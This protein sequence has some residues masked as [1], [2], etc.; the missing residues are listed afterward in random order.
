MAIQTPTVPLD[1]GAAGTPSRP[2]REFWHYFR[3]S[4]GAVLG[5]AITVLL[6]LTAIFADV[7]APHDPI[8]QYRDAFLKPPVYYYAHSI[9]EVRQLAPRFSQWLEALPRSS[10]FRS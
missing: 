6:V 7:I 4:K 10:A 5:L 1:A 2:I 8:E 9:P 3:E